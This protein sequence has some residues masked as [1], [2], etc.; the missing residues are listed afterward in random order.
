MNQ[1]CSGVTGAGL[2]SVVTR[3]I[4]RGL[5]HNQC[6]LGAYRSLLILQ[7]D[8]TSCT[9]QVQSSGVLVPLDVGGGRGEELDAAGEGD[10]AAWLH[11]HRG[12]SVDD[13]GGS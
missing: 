8:S 4:I 1:D 9:V 11:E 12:L 10:G 13:C 3:V 6:A 7:T 5:G 2:T